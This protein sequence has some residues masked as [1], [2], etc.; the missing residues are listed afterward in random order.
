V[1]WPVE[2]FCLGLSRKRFLAWRAGRRDLAPA[3]R[4]GLA[5]EAH[6]EAMAWG[7]RVFRTHR[8][9]PLGVAE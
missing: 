6:R 3:R 5:W 4:D 9:A 7:Y 2:R 8:V 1:G